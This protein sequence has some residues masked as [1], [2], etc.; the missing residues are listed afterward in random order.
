MAYFEELPNI[1]QPSLLSG[2]NRIEDRVIVKNLFKRS[3]LRTDVDQAITAFNYYYIEDQQRPDVLAQ[4]LYG[5]SELDWVVLTSNNITNVRSQWPLNHDDLYSYMLEKYGSEQN[6][7]G[8]H[9]SETIKTIDKYNRVVLKGGLEVDANFTFTFVGTVTSSTGSLIKVNFGGSSSNTI[10]P[11]ASITNY[12]YEV[13][14]NEEKRRIRILKPAYLG[15]FISEHKQ[16]M[17]YK[18]SSNYISKKLSKDYKVLYTGKNGNVAHE[19]IIDIRPIKASSGISEEDLAK[20]LIDF[21]YHA[22]TM[23]WPVAGTIMI[24]PTE[25]EN[26]EEIDKFCNALIKIKKEIDLVESSKFDKIDN[27]LKNAPHTYIELASNDWSHKYTR[28]EAAFPTEFVKNNKYWPPVARVDNVYGDRNLV[29]SCP[30]MD[31][32]KDEAA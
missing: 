31:E 15:A 29:C 20:R 6:I 17:K 28:E 13:K 3:K 4:E 7:L 11:V 21:G 22:P 32:Y 8:I 9:H 14:Q 12:D 18:R 30:S 23:S 10:T 5:D 2:S 27:P 19:C 26:L 16:I 24:E 1:S 25:S